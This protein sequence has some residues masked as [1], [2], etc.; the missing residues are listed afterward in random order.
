MEPRIQYAKTEDGVN[1]A[2]W[3]L[4]EGPPL[5]MTSGGPSSKS[6]QSW[7]VPEG[8]AYLEKLA[9]DRLLIRYD[10]RGTGHSEHDLSEVSFEAYVADIEAVA[11][12]AKLG[13][14]A[15]WGGGLCSL[16][17]IAYAVR[18]PERISKL[19]LSHA[20]ACGADFF[21]LNRLRKAR[22]SA[23]EDPE[24]FLQIFVLDMLGWTAS[25]RAPFLFSSARARASFLVNGPF[26]LMRSFSP[27][28]SSTSY[29][30]SGVFGRSSTTALPVAEPFKP[31]RS[32]WS[33]AVKKSRYANV[34]PR[35][36]IPGFTV[37]FTVKSERFS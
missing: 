11:D 3:T 2:Y 24:L 7:Q 37:G 19:I 8:R 1:I 16:F 22:E 20:S 29:S 34:T 4:G 5:L 27:W 14:F 31:G 13:T 10:H 33:D 35:R 21:N 15:L 18:H 28:S 30:L 9:R 6:L 23:D 17:T 26:P 36:V 32:P 12:K 25:E